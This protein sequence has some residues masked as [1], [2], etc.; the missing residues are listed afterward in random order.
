MTQDST[1][2]TPATEINTPAKPTKPLRFKIGIALLILYPLFYLV[3]PI[4]PFLPFAAGLKIGIVA[5]ILGAAEGVLLLGIACV[6]KET[7]QAIKAK[8]K[9]GRKTSSSA[10]TRM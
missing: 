1:L 8:L 5:G 7:Y 10:S 2:N 4:A 6:G 3:I 9:L